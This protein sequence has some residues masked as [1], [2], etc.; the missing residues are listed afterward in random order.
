SPESW[1]S[2]RR[3]PKGP[4]CRARKHPPPPAGRP[5]FHP[6]NLPS[7]QSSIRPLEQPEQPLTSATTQ[8]PHL[9]DLIPPQGMIG[10]DI[11]DYHPTITE[12]EP[13]PSDKAPPT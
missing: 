11:G 5:I 6:A 9:P 8:P 12:C 10:A 3:T 1:E 2:G 13:M 4:R 7:G